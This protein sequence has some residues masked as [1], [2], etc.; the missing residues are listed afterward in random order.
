[1][2]QNLEE[3]K[4]KKTFE[5]LIDLTVECTTYFFSNNIL[6]NVDAK[7]PVPPVTQTLFIVI[8]LLKIFFFEF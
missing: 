7:N 5:E 4:K 2:R 8:C 6:I 1:M 3:K